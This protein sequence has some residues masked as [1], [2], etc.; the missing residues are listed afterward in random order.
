MHV[1]FFRAYLQALRSISPDSKAS[2]DGL[3]D[4]GAELPGAASAASVDK[5]PHRDIQP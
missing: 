5:Q 1:Y 2:L 3:T 4:F